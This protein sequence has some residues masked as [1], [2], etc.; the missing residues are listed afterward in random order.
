MKMQTTYTS[1]AHNQIASAVIMANGSPF[2]HQLQ[3]V[4]VDYSGDTAT[5]I[6]M[7]S[8][9]IAKLTG[10]EHKHV[11]RDIKTMLLEVGD[12]PILDHVHKVK[13]A[14]GYTSEIK[15]PGIL[16]QTL[17]TGYSI[18]LR[19]RVLQR[20]NEL[21]VEA[22]KPVTFGHLLL[23]Y[24]ARL[25]QKISEDADKVEFYETMTGT[26]NLF[27]PVTASKLF[28][29]GRTSYLQYLRDHKILMSRP[30]RINMP[31]Q[32]YMD[33]GLFEVKL[34]D[35]E[36]SKTGEAEAKAHPMLTGKGVI[37]LKQFIDQNG[38]DGL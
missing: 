22:A 31:Y 10:K 20:L 27:N 34:G 30:N 12:G 4:S 14:R 36:N 23:D 28:G 32:K 26:E 2:I 29:T 8:L 38:R 21:E 37:W 11:I 15:L 25:E 19:Y 13:D 35:Y 17:I 16:T 24:T 1:A 9:E 3:G 6:T 7:S 33:A 5:P 18:P